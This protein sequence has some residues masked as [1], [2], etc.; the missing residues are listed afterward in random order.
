M[1]KKKI[2][3]VDDSSV[4]RSEITL[5]LSSAG[6]RVVEAANGAEG[7]RR[8]KENADAALVLSDINMPEM[9][10]IEM[11][12]QIKAG[13][14]NASL[15]VVMLTTEGNVELIK[16]AKRVGAK[17]WIVKPFVN[18]LLLETVQKLAGGS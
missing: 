18:H 4:V 5:V 1:T 10:G 17:A 16:Q 8:L 12:T 15:P 13:G 7:L 3:V 9:N 2:I 6:Y 11:L 14:N